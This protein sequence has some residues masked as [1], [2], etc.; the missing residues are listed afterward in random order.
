[1]VRQTLTPEILLFVTTHGNT[2]AVKQKKAANTLNINFSHKW[3]FFCGNLFHN[4]SC[5]S[6]HE[7]YMSFVSELGVIKLNYKRQRVIEV[8]VIETYWTNLQRWHVT[9][10][11]PMANPCCQKQGNWENWFLIWAVFDSFWNQK[12]KLTNLSPFSTKS[13]LKLQQPAYW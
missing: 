2:T 11:R 7:L 8:L 6:F 3:I 13:K 12:L 1:M 5:G 9:T 4:Y 10:S